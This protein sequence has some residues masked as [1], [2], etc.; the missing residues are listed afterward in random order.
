MDAVNWR[1][2]IRVFTITKLD[3]ESG[4]EQYIARNTDNTKA[5][6][7]THSSYQQAISKQISISELVNM[8]CRF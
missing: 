5:Y 4:K 3:T 6:I 7:V 2:L 1:D 8:I